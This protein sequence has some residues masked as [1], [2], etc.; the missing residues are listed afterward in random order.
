MEGTPCYPNLDYPGDANLF[1]FNALHLRRTQDDAGR[2]DYQLP[3]FN[4]ATTDDLAVGL[5]GFADDNWRTG[6]PRAS[7]STSSRPASPRTTG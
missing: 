6:T 7:C 1:V 5:L 3:N 2:V 4:Y